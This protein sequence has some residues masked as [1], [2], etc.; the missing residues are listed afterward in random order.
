MKLRKNT[1]IE[2]SIVVKTNKGKIKLSS[3]CEVPNSKISR[4]IKEQEPNGYLSSLE[5]MN[6]IA[7]KFILVGGGKLSELHFKT[8]QICIFSWNIY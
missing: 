6:E 3:K 2:N 4:F 1:E 7:N 5:T 8:S